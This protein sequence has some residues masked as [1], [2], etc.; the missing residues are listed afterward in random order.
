MFLEPAVEGGQFEFPN[1]E[2]NITPKKGDVLLY[3]NRLPNAQMDLLAS[4]RELPSVEG[5]KWTL[6]KYYRERPLR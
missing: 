6:T 3:H 4:N 1:A 2:L 5:E